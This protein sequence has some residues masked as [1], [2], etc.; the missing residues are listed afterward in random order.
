MFRISNNKLFEWLFSKV[1]ASHSGGPG[2]IPRQELQTSLGRSRETTFLKALTS[3][4]SPPA[5]TKLLVTLAFLFA[6]FLP[7]VHNPMSSAARLSV[8]VASPAQNFERAVP[9]RTR[10]VPLQRVTKELVSSPLFQK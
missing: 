4:G 1:L 2:S 10:V 3:S 7:F 9:R 8:S 5:D 6:I